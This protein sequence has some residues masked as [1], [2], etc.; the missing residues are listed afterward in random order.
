MTTHFFLGANSGEGFQSLY[1]DLADLEK[2]RDLIVLKGGPGVG[3]STFMKQ[4]GRAAEEAGQQVEY[5]WCSG[6]PDSLDAVLLPECAAAVVDG[7]SPH[8]VEPRYPAAVDRY[9]NLG[10]FYD[11]DALKKRRLEVVTH[12]EAYKEAY[13]RAFHC[14]KAA[15]QVERSAFSR[16]AQRDHSPRAAEKGRRGGRYYPPPPGFHDPQGICLAL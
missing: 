12:T 5:I 8:V 6:D 14:L 11:V 13:Q 7:T 16:M 1:P 10:Q 15:R 2:I 4:V 9:V 3:K